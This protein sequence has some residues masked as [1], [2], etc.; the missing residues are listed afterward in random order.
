MILFCQTLTV[1][2]PGTN[3][4]NGNK[5][6]SK[7]INLEILDDDD[8]LSKNHQV[9]ENYIF[10]FGFSDNDTEKPSPRITLKRVPNNNPRNANGCS[11]SSSSKKT[12]ASIPKRES[13]GFSDSTNAEDDP[14]ASIQNDEISN[15]SDDDNDDGDE[16]SASSRKRRKRLSSTK[17]SKVIDL[18]ILDDGEFSKNQ[19][20]E[21]DF[22]E[23]LS[24]DNDAEKLSPRKF[25]SSPD[26]DSEEEELSFRKRRKRASLKKKRYQSEEQEA[27]LG[28]DEDFSDSSSEDEEED[29]TDVEYDKKPPR[30][31]RRNKYLL[32]ALTNIVQLTKAEQN[33][34][35]ESIE[36]KED[37]ALQRLLLNSGFIFQLYPHQFMAVRRVWAHRLFPN[38]VNCFSLQILTHRFAVSIFITGCRFT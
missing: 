14:D 23:Y 9:S 26:D 35:L 31:H 34:M 24:S 32:P 37:K 10:E 5:K 18:E 4:N 27:W 6:R 28:S 8:T 20:P 2:H 38:C 15:F 19:V 30:H 1:N 17:E 25:L 3:K 7:V 33:S 16:E 22:F 13:L 29:L 12:K 21:N 11:F 36:R